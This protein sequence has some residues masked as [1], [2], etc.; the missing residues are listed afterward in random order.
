MES[1]FLGAD[2]HALHELA[3]Q[4]ETQ[5]GVIR[6][7]RARFNHIVNDALPWQGPDAFFFRHVWNSSYAPTLADGAELLSACSRQ[8]ADQA[9]QQQAA[10]ER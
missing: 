3:R 4:M 5:A 6:Q 2:P 10:S 7:T 8:L 9:A 1:G